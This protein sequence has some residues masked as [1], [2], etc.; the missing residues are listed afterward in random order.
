DPLEDL[1][2]FERV[3]SQPSSSP[4]P[5]ASASPSQQASAS[6]APPRQADASPTPPD[7]P[8]PDAERNA[9]QTKNGV[10]PA[11]PPTPQRPETGN[12]PAPPVATIRVPPIEQNQARPLQVAP[13]SPT[14]LPTGAAP[15][16]SPTPPPTVK[17]IFF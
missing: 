3:S 1:R 15:T 17:Y 7:I 10:T 9:A 13:T 4:S 14:P 2:T 5:T 12:R 11:Q 6:P 8:G 16:G